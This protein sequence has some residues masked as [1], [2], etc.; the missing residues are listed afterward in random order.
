MACLKW[1][2]ASWWSFNCMQIIAKL[3]WMFSLTVDSESSDRSRRLAKSYKSNRPASWT[4]VAKLISACC[5][6]TK[7]VQF[8]GI[9]ICEW[10]L[11]D[12]HP[13]EW[14][15]QSE[16]WPC[17]VGLVALPQHLTAVD[18]KQINLIR[19]KAISGGCEDRSSVSRS[20]HSSTNAHWLVI[21][22]QAKLLIQ[23][24]STYI[25]VNVRIGGVVEQSRLVHTL[26]FLRPIQS[27]KNIGS[28]DVCIHVVW[29][30]PNGLLVQ[31]LSLVQSG[32]VHRY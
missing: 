21:S 2:S 11:G 10:L 19:T 28:I 5:E 25:V 17:P 1:S 8:M 3:K 22:R 16:Q 20:V 15:S 31:L 26:R 12:G 23:T 6:Q 4:M 9:L 32:L 30:H 27:Q 13:F 24:E 14:P 7:W 18:T 29:P